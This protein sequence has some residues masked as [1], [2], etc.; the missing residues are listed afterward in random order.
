ML[1]PLFYS[2]SEDVRETPSLENSSVLERWVLLLAQVLDVSG[3]D[4]VSW[5][6]G[7]LRV[8][9]A[10]NRDGVESGRKFLVWVLLSLKLGCGRAGEQ[11]AHRMTLNHHGTSLGSSNALGHRNKEPQY[12]RHPGSVHLPHT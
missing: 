7:T 2:I 9:M 8:F 4:A 5:V 12:S 10:L 6:K 1:L 11:G 3:L